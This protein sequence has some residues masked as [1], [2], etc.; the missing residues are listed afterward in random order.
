[1]EFLLARIAEDEQ[2]AKDAIGGWDGSDDD[3][4]WEQDGDSKYIE[5]KCLQIYDEGGHSV[6]QAIH[7]A[8]WDPHSVLEDCKTKRAIID[9]LDLDGMP[10][11]QGHF[12]AR[13]VLALM[14]LRYV[15]H[16]DYQAFGK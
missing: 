16:P 5:G 4:V 6:T 12:V 10:K 13:S 14:A 1:M 15:D 3:G 9:F 8:R 2:V 11:G 7:I